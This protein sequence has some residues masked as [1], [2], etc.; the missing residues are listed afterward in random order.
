M[1]KYF[2]YAT[3]LCR[4]SLKHEQVV[5]VDDENQLINY[6]SITLR[7]FSIKEHYIVS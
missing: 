2:E 7:N 4:Y 5:I 6:I 1:K 3:F